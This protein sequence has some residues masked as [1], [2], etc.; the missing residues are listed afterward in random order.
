MT[1]VMKTLT[2]GLRTDRSQAALNRTKPLA[3]PAGLLQITSLLQI[4]GLFQGAGLV[5]SAG[6]ALGLMAALVLAPR[7]AFGDAAGAP[8]TPTPEA[9]DLAAE[10]KFTA[11]GLSLGKARLAIRIRG[12]RYMVQ[13]LMNTGG[14]ASVFFKS[15]YKVLGLGHLAEDGAVLPSRYDSDF[16]GRSTQKLVSLIYGADGLPELTAADPPYGERILQQPV[17]DEE[18]RG[19]VDPM[20]AWIHFMTGTSVEDDHPCGR[21]VPVY[22]GR[23]RYNLDL[24][25]LG[26]EKAKVKGGRVFRGT[27]YR[28]LFQ[29]TPVAGYKEKDLAE[30]AVPIPPLKAVIAPITTPSGRRM[31]VPVQVSAN[32]PV[33]K[34][35]LKIQSLDFAPVAD[36]LLFAE[37]G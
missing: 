25:F 23:R 22:D 26:T 35:H 24:T 19:T 14:L 15:E 3:W 4:T 17:S 8:V 11:L 18:K 9:T 13:S 32:A 27:A 6:L 28:C 20:G 1:D 36:G 2:A 10:F 31:L 34:V 33:G 7:T 37:G 29:Y 12:D 5:R 16:V 21:S 30:D